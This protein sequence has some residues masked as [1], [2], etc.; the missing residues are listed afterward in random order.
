QAFRDE[1]F[2]YINET[3]VAHGVVPFESDAALDQT[4]IA[5]AMHWSLHWSP[6]EKDGYPGRDFRPR[7]VAAACGT[8][9]SLIMAT[10]A[11]DEPRLDHGLI[12]PSF[13]ARYWESD[14]NL[15]APFLNPNYRRLGVGIYDGL[16]VGV[17]GSTSSP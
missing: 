15:S 16:L 2:I 12:D 14:D 6:T 7:D 9:A 8:T 13:P 3:R 1:A 5:W 4:A 17:L 11:Q 10:D